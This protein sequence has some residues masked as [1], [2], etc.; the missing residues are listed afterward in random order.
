MVLSSGVSAFVS[1]IFPVCHVVVTDMYFVRQVFAVHGLLH[2][3]D[4]PEFAP[5]HVLQDVPQTPS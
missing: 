1:C 3:L 2:L 5:S 4:P